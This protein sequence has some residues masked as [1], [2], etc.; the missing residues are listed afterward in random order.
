MGSFPI[1]KSPTLVE[2]WT[3]RIEKMVLRFDYRNE[4]VE[5]VDILYRFSRE[6]Y[7]AQKPRSEEG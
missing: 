3:V 2:E 1:K 5:T 6:V 4:P 7:P